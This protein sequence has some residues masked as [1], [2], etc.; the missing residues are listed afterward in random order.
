MEPCAA[1]DHRHSR[2][3]VRAA[4]PAP[5]A[6]H[7]HAHRRRA[8]A[9][10]GRVVRARRRVDRPDARRRHPAASTP[11]FPARCRSAPTSSSSWSSSSSA[12]PT[13]APASCWSTATAATPDPVQR[14]AN[15][16]LGEGRRVLAWWPHIRNGDAHAG[17]TETSM[18]LALA[19][20]LVRM[21]PRR[22]GPTGADRRSHRRA[23]RRRRAGRQPQRG[24][25][26]PARRD[27]Q[28]RQGPA[29][30]ADHRSRRG[31]RRMAS[32]TDLVRCSTARTVGTTAVVIA[33]S[34]L[35]L[36]RL[37][38]GGHACRRGDR[39]GGNRC[40]PATPS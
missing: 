33:G 6:R 40:P 38:T 36:F 16:L 18:M 25:R 5:A 32:V 10:P 39:A 22:G 2:R 1:A 3:V 15:T 21:T 30:P 13:G 17:E 8:G 23:A 37:S 7:R 12:A 31:R 20:A 19:P 11:A 9:G 4:R 28:P 24:P 34:P 14:A 27:G 26:R 35:R 29:H